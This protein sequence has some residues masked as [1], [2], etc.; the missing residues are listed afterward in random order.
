MDDTQHTGEAT[1]TEDEQMYTALAWQTKVADGIQSA[2]QVLP[3]TCPKLGFS[4][5]AWWERQLALHYSMRALPMLKGRDYMLPALAKG[6]AGFLPRPMKKGQALRLLREALS[7]G[8]LVTK[9]VNA[10]TLPSLR[11]FMPSLAF[12]H[13]VDSTRRKALGKWAAWLP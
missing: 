13:G 12:R 6:R 5:Y 10:I 9:E 11:V 2:T 1:V 8:G 4:S 3:L 7:V